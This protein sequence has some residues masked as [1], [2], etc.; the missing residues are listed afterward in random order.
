M[1]ANDND[2]LKKNPVININFAKPTILNIDTI[3][4]KKLLFKRKKFFFILK[5][6]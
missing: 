4:K 1:F 3:I 2:R 5:Y 6:T